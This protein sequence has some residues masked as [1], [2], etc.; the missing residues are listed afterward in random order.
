MEI[1][2][3]DY[4]ALGNGIDYTKEIQKASMKVEIFIY[5]KEYIYK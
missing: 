1:N 2:V 3:K 5:Q 4:G